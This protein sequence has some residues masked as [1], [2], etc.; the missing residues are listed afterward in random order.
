MSL[1]CEDF[2]LRSYAER[3]PDFFIS[4]IWWWH[5]KWRPGWKAY[6]AE[7]ARQGKDQER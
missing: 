6:Q 7:L 4:K 3:K 5:T 1:K 2:K